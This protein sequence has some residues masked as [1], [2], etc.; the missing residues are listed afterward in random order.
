[1]R[2]A[3]LR[4]SAN[5]HEVFAISA[6]A[7]YGGACL[8]SRRPLQ[9]LHIGELNLLNC[10]HL[11]YPKVNDRCVRIHDAKEWDAPRM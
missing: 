11:V 7:S 1:M 10:S 9:E 4:Q 6:G 3:V 2:F 8:V 5:E